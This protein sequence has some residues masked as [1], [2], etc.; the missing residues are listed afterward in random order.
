MVSMMPNPFF[1]P[2]FFSVEFFYTLAIVVLCFF[3]FFRT[4]GI[5]ELSRYKGIRYFRTAFLFFGIAYA[6]RFLFHIFM[7]S[8]IALDIFRPQR[9]FMHYSLMFTTYFSTLAILYLIYCSIW[10][11]VKHS[12]FMIV[13]NIIAATLTL[14]TFMVRSPLTIGT[15]QTILLVLAII[16]G[17]LFGKKE[18]KEKRISKTKMMYYLVILFW[19]F[20]LITSG[21][22]RLLD[23]MVRTVLQVISVI[24][25]AIVFY[26][27]LK[28]T[29]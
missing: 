3:I 18:K 1:G 22:N 16:L 24:L 23:P 26:R 8:N 15:S 20:N 5:Y 6:A 19:L 12:H 25:F 29:R 2:V 7:M 13:S 9:E 14:L 10:E 28:W 21:P 11:K 4:G 17:L 27:V